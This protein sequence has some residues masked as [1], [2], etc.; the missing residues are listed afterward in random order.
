MGVVHAA[1]HLELKSR[2]AIKVLQPALAADENARARFLREARLAAS[3]EGDHSTKIYDVGAGSD[4]TPYMVMEYLAGESVDARLG[5]TG[6]L[7]LTDTAT[8]MM[9]LLSVLAEAHARGLVHRDLKPGN[10]FLVERR[11][12]PIWV[13][14]MDFGISKVGGGVIE[15]ASA[16]DVALTEPRTLLGSPEYMSPEQLRD[17]A[18]VDARA[19]IWACGVVMFELLSGSMPFEGDTLVDLY[20]QIVSKTPKPISEV[21][22]AAV[23]DELVQLISR[24]LEKDPANRPASAAEL[25]EVLSPFASES[26]RALLPRVRAWSE[27]RDGGLADPRAALAASSIAPT[28]AAPSQSDAIVR[29]TP[30]GRHV[31]EPAQRP[32]R[33]GA[34]VGLGLVL[35]ASVV[36]YIVASRSPKTLE[37]TSPS[38]GPVVAS[39]PR[40]EPVD[41]PIASADHTEPVAPSATASAQVSPPPSASPQKKPSAEKKAQKGTPERI[42][43]IDGIEI[44]P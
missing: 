35:V 21:A 34:L 9:Q 14:V 24:C 7:S 30:G 22:K 41:A 8:V 40:L 4:G 10:L 42:Q 32:G 37:K 25:A 20:V 36:S 44:I 18:T 31:A 29:A 15:P 39:V 17:S 26:A 6:A 2:V 3:I 28:L 33:R 23:P 11:G 43:G 5:R 38:A 19:D 27:S 16:D 12:E 1:Y 13:K